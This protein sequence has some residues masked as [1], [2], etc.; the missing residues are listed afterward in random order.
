MS[1]YRGV[2]IQ[3]C[4]LL[5]APALF[6]GYIEMRGITI[7]QGPLS[8]LP[9]LIM[10]RVE[11]RGGPLSTWSVRLIPYLDISLPQSDLAVL[12]HIG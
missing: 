4:P 11:M 5:R 3:Q 10:G 8:R 6:I 9:A 12:L 2:A 1:E 7:R